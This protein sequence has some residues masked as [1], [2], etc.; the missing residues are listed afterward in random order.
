MTDQQQLDLDSL[1]RRFEKDLQK[2][3][4]TDGVELIRRDYLIR[5]T[6]T[7]V[8]TEFEKRS[9]AIKTKFNHLPSAPKVANEGELIAAI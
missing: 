2:S 3:R 9:N 8:A 4:T 1:C 6:R 5:A 7:G